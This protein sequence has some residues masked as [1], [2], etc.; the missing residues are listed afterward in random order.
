MT[1]LKKDNIHL[2]DTLNDARNQ[3]LN[4]NNECDD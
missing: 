4:S 1:D 3:L 2:N